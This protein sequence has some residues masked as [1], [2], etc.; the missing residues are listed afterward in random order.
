MRKLVSAVLCTAILLAAAGC[1]S[2]SDSSSTT[3]QTA[4]TAANP[5][6]TSTTTTAKT[7]SSAAAA[8]KAFLKRVNPICADYNRDAK[9]IQKQLRAAEKAAGRAVGNVDTYSA[10]LKRATASAQRAS[11][12]FA[13]V[14]PPA[15]EAAQAALIGRALAALA[16]GNGLLLDAARSDDPQAFAVATQALQQVTPQL[17]SLMREYG[18]TVC[19]ARS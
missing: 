3:A 15:S 14:K 17:Q 18:M 2:S 6:P 5:L 13:E 11:K 1:G 12:R 9:A 10:P 16:K 7:A 8:H 4:P 19:G